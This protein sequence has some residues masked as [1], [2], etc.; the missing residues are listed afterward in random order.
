MWI[1]SGHRSRRIRGTVAPSLAGTGD[2]SSLRGGT[3]EK[4]HVKVFRSTFEIPT[5][6]IIYLRF[7]HYQRP[8]SGKLFRP[9]SKLLLIRAFDPVE[10]NHAA[11]KKSGNFRTIR[12]TLRDARTGKEVLL[13]D[14]KEG[15]SVAALESGASP[16]S[17]ALYF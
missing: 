4:T 17:E 6:S 16:W 1:L 13:R 12:T 15:L 10:Q 9:C 14:I 3:T 7:L 2:G 8:A 5:A 11:L